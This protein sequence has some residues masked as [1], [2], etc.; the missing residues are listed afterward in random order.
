MVLYQ[1][2]S[3][4]L[5]DYNLTYSKNKNRGFD[6]FLTATPLKTQH[7]PFCKHSSKPIQ[8]NTN[9]QYTSKINPKQPQTCSTINQNHLYIWLG[10]FPKLSLFKQEGR[11]DLKRA[12]VR[13]PTLTHSLMIL[14]L[15]T[16]AL[17]KGDFDWL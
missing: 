11:E 16:L 7:F 4:H 6:K 17:C 3:L 13:K 15:G 10:F 2:E 12:K 8:T 9:Q 1:L 5:D 14:D